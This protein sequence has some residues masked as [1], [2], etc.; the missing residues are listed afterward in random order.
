MNGAQVSNRLN[1]KTK[2]TVRDIERLAKY[3]DVHPSIFFR[4]SAELIDRRRFGGDGKVTHSKIRPY[5]AASTPN[6]ERTAAH[7]GHLS[8]VDTR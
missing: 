4:D 6:P 7:R 5:I 8:A 2:L 1:G 3:F